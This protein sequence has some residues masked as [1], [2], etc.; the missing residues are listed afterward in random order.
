M[1]ENTQDL[2]GYVSK[3]ESEVDRLVEDVP[4][5]KQTVQDMVLDSNHR[6]RM[7]DKEL[8]DDKLSIE[9]L[10]ALVYSNHTYYETKLEMAHLNFDVQN[11]YMG[12]PSKYVGK[13]EDEPDKRSKTTRRSV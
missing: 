6:K 5:I 8:N 7:V 1:S 4:D 12:V 13:A 9:K 2:N 11:I 10:K 3:I